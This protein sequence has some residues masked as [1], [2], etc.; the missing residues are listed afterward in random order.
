MTATA[1]K[2]GYRPNVCAVITDAQRQQVLM[3]RRVD[4]TLGEF[5]WQFPQGGLDAD[6]SP[7]QGLL[8]ELREEIGTAEVTVVGRLPA[9]LR[10]E[11]PPDVLAALAKKDPRKA[12]F[13]GQ[14]QH[15]FL[16]LL[17]VAPETL[18]F[19]HQP[20]E[21]DAW[22]WV[23]PAQAIELVVPFKRVVYRQALTGLKLL[24]V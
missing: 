21:F 15:W 18:H 5:R 14:S 22:R 3:F 8:R 11:Y 23:T 7:E 19:D 1:E 16:V 12:G 13:V 6:E 24:H 2:A 4:A 17:N 9:P 10:Y 20:Q